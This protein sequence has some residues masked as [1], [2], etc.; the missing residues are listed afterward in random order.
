MNSMFGISGALR[1]VILALLLAGAAAPAGAAETRV[2]FSDFYIGPTYQP[3]PGLM[4]D[5]RIS[6]KIQGLNGQRVEILG[7]MDGILPRDGMFFMLLKEPLIACP[8]HSMDFDWGNF[9][10]VFLKKRTAYIDGPIKVTGRL[11][12]GKKLDETGF[13]SY[14]R[15]YD[16]TIARA[17]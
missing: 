12:V 4:P 8:F 2:R 1:V 6:P 5:F 15:I 16:A 13:T 3:A 9:A 17:Q 11:E 14:V 7:F 10:P